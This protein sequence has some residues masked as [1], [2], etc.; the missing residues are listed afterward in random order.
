VAVCEQRAL[1]NVRNPLAEHEPIREWPPVDPGAALRL[2]KS[3]RSIRTYK[4]E[5]VDR[6][7]IEKLLQATRWAPAGH[8][9]KHLEYIVVNGRDAVSRVHD[10]VVGWMADMWDAGNELA[11]Q[12]HFDALVRAHQRGEDRVL[13]GA[14]QLIVAHAPKDLWIAQIDTALALEYVELYALSLGLGT[15]WGGFVQVCAGFHPPLQESLGIPGERAIS[16]V[17]MVGYP[18]TTYHSIPTRPPLKL[19]WVE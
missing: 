8:N 18:E 7:T 3:R 14:P 10:I 1:D 9:M 19:E 12:Y 15:C 13:R 16:G 11:R 5:P 4:E 2:L 17:M 6:A